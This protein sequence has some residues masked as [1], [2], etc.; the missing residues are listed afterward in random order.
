MA[1]P[2]VSLSFLAWQQ[3]HMTCLAKKKGCPPNKTRYNVHICL[4]ITQNQRENPLNI[5]FRNSKSMEN[6]MGNSIP[7]IP[8]ETTNLGKFSGISKDFSAGEKRR[9]PRQGVLKPSRSNTSAST[10]KVRMWQNKNMLN[11][12]GSEH[13]PKQMRQKIH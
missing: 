3:T 2:G 7:E 9:R 1:N 11:S 4:H 5:D 8:F 6:S 12:T 10:R 13:D